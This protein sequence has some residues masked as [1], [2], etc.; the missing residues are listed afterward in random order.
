VL[1]GGNGQSFED[2]IQEINTFTQ[3]NKEL[4]ILNLSQGLNTDL[5]RKSRSLNLAEWDQLLDQLTGDTGLNHLFVAPNPT[6]VDLSTLPLDQF[7]GAGQAAVVIIVQPGDKSV[8]LHEYHY[9]GAY[10]N[11]QMKVYNQHSHIHKLDG[12]VRNQLQKMH[13]NRTSPDSPLFLLSWTH[14]PYS[15]KVFIGPSTLK[16]SEKAL[17]RIYTDLFSEC[18]KDT[19]PNILYLDGVDSN[20]I[21]A[22]AMAINDI[23]AVSESGASNTGQA[24][25]R[26]QTFERGPS[27]GSMFERS[28][29]IFISG[30]QFTQSTQQGTSDGMNSCSSKV[31]S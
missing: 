14:R 31:W 10:K 23:A 18:S 12:M 17:P 21:T 29:N 30:G 6:L 16:I 11:T 13:D 2:I 26:P 8:T 22:L 28:N 5:G 3:E 20:D 27:G 19:Y 25:P 4:I 24:N 9:R 7:I 15:T 1:L